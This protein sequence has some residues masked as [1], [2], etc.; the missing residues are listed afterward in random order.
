MEISEGRLPKKGTKSEEEYR[1]AIDAEIEHLRQEYLPDE[2]EV[3]AREIDAAFVFSCLKKDQ[4]GDGELFVAL[5]RDKFIFN[6]S[7]QEWYFWNGVSWELDKNL[8]AGKVIVRQAYID[9]AADL[10]PGIAHG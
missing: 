4:Y 9:N 5:F 3:E 1:R 10:Q 7:S 2:E 6:E 8:R